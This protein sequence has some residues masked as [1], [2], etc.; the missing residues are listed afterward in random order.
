[1]KLLKEKT[2]QSKG[3]ALDKTVNHC[4]NVIMFLNSFWKDISKYYM[5]SL[6]IKSRILN[7]SKYRDYISS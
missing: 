2:T 6:S 4:E 1:M 7:A 5:S 3:K